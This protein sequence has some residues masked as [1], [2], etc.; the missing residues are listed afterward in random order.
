[1]V[2]GSVARW[3]GRAAVLCGPGADVP[4]YRCLWP[5]PADGRTA[6]VPTCDAAGVLGVAPG[7]V[8]M[9]QATETLKLLLGLGSPLAGVLWVTDLRS[10]VTHRV[11]L[12]RDPLCAACGRGQDSP[13]RRRHVPPPRAPT[14]A[15][16]GRRRAPRSCSI[17]PS[18]E[19]RRVSRPDA[20][21][22]PS[23]PEISPR[24]SPTA[25]APPSRRCS[26]T[27]ASRGSTRSPASPAPASS[28]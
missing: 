22:D 15:T 20:A 19:P 6:D 3:E 9:M 4:C 18:P 7:L 13:D 24:R 25:C 26:S 8:G 16:R 21:A 2:H 17:P 10:H 12:A 23:I 11:R 14:P 27:C 5:D 28:P 1:M